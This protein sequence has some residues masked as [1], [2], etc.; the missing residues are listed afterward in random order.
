M[1]SEE[2]LFLSIKV[3][4]N[5]DPPYNTGNESWVYNDNVND[6]HIIK[7]LGDVV[8]KEGE[9][10]S[11]HNKR[12]YY[13]FQ[14]SATINLKNNVRSMIYYNNVAVPDALETPLNGS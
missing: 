9:D 4:T 6:Q 2:A 11:C 3:G 7:W 8:G 10:L 12:Q 13:F 5:I 14:I 1:Y